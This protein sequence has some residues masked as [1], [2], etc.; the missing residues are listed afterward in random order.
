MDM[1]DILHKFLRAERTG[2]WAPHLEAISEKLPFMTAGVN[3]YMRSA[4][5]FRGMWSD[6]VIAYGPPCRRSRHRAGADGKYEIQRWPHERVRDDGAAMFDIEHWRAE[7][8][9]DRC[10]TST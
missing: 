7:Q 1:V 4:E 3:L 2:N 10:K 8:G 5:G 6:K 9:H